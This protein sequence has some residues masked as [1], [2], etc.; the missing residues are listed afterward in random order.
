MDDSDCFGIYRYFNRLYKQVLSCKNERRRHLGYLHC[1]CLFGKYLWRLLCALGLDW[2]EGKEMA[3]W[4]IPGNESQ[5]C[6][7]GEESS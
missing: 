7:M 2:K 4:Q 6:G 5:R 1:D 3:K